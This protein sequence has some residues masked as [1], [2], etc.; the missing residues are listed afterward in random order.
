MSAD[1]KII[2]EVKEAYLGSAIIPTAHMALGIQLTEIREAFVTELMNIIDTLY[3]IT[4]LK[5]QRLANH[6]STNQIIGAIVLTLFSSSTNGFHYKVIGGCHNY[7]AAERL[8]QM[9]PGQDVFKT[10]L[11]SIYSNTLS[12][13]AILWLANRHN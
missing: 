8:S 1:L 2:E 6:N 10:R 3:D 5:K 13:E 9:Y 12:D 11:C 4:H 7:S